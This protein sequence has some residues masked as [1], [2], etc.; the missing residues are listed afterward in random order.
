MSDLRTAL[1]ET[2]SAQLQA[3]AGLQALLGTPLR[4]YEQRPAMATFPFMTLGESEQ[5]DI[6]A[7][8]VQV[9]SHVCAFH[10]WSRQRS[11]R[12]VRQVLAQLREALHDATLANVARVQEEFSGV[13]WDEAA[14]ASRGVARY[15]LIV[16]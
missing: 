12:E 4:L 8:G 14:Q 1:T 10:V 9:E 6:S 2:V 13:L 7:K 16:S 5:R 15:R 3:H 11:G